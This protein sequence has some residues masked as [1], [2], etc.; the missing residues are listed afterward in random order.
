M[1][2]IECTSFPWNEALEITVE[3]DEPLAFVDRTLRVENIYTEPKGT[4]SSN[5][6]ALNHA[7]Q[8]LHHTIVLWLSGVEEPLMPILLIALSVHV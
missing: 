5:I 2:E 7:E 1:V 4:S 3:L 6:Q 8:L